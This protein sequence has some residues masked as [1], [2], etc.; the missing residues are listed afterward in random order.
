MP[1]NTFEVHALNLLILLLKTEHTWGTHIQ[2]PWVLKNVL[3]LTH[4]QHTFN[5]RFFLF[6]VWRY[7][8]VN[9]AWITCLCFEFAPLIH[10]YLCAFCFILLIIRCLFTFYLY[11]Y[12]ITAETTGRIAQKVEQTVLDACC[13]VPGSSPGSSPIL[14]MNLRFYRYLD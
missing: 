13:C 1:F 14:S 11:L 7:M 9:I 6:R 10:C 12:R 2:H 8:Y 3:F 4:I 5:L